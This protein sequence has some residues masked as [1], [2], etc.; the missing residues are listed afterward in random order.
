MP[1]GKLERILG[2]A[3]TDSEFRKQMLEK[4]EAALR[5]YDLTPEQISALKAIPSDA[6]EKFASKITEILGKDLTGS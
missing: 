5:E 1:L 4:P 6:L 2:R 3:A